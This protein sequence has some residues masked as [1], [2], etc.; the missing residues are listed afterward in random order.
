MQILH[1]RKTTWQYSEFVQNA[2]KLFLAWQLF[3][4]QEVHQFR[5]QMLFE[6][7]LL[8]LMQS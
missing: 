2:V 1:P 3:L 4:L 8:L 6:L 7:L 5:N